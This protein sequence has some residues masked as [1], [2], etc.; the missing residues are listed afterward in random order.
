MLTFP[1]QCVIG[2][3]DTTMTLYAFVFCAWRVCQRQKS[4]LHS[5]GWCHFPC[6]QKRLTAV[7]R[8][9]IYIKNNFFNDILWFLPRGFLNS[10]SS[11]NMAVTPER[12][13]ILRIFRSRSSSL[14]EASERQRRRKK[15]GQTL[16]STAVIEHDRI[17]SGRLPWLWLMDS[18]LLPGTRGV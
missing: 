15:E 4:I 9:I 16:I 14:G 17:K 8:K 5:H 1:Y 3:K 13:H 18:H 10:P 7:K 6:R 11:K 2:Y 12:K